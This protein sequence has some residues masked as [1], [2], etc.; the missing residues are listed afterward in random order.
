M[1]KIMAAQA[2]SNG[3]EGMANYYKT[4]KKTL[5]INTRHPVIK[6]M[7]DKVKAGKADTSL[8]EIALVL[9]ETA[10]LRSGFEVKNTLDFASR[11]EKVIRSSLGVSLD[12]TPEVKVAPAPEA[13][14]EDV[15]ANSKKD[16]EDEEV[17][18]DHDEL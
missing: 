16:E 9:Y 6:S 8:E 4:L 7:K 18:I 10:L 11:I 2:L 17:D 5:E 12:A 1:E 15:K 14:A 13:S 3:D